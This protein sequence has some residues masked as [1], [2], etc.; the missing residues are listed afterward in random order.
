MFMKRKKK[1]K[2]QKYKLGIVLKNKIVFKL[3][4]PNSNFII[5]D[6]LNII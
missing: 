4:Y 1:K 3:V 6:L 5:K 2:K